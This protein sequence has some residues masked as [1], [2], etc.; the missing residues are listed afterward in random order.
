MCEAGV[1]Y[2][3]D[4]HLDRE[5]FIRMGSAVSNKLTIIWNKTLHDENGPVN[6]LERDAIPLKISCKLQVRENKSLD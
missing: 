2:D 5:A 6:D 4:F 1:V 3:C